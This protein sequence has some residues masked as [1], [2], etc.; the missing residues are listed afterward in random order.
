MLENKKIDGRYDI[1]IVP[2][3]YILEVYKNGYDFVRKEIEL[4]Q[5]ENNINIDLNLEK[6]YYLNVNVINYETGTY[7]DKAMINVNKKLIQLNKLS[8][9]SFRLRI[10]KVMM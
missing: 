3:R 9:L 1:I 4:I 8:Y 7:V 2:G 6:K 10:Q 5:G